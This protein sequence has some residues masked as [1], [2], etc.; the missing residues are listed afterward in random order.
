MHS[1]HGWCSL[2]MR[3]EHTAA[4]GMQ[5]GN[6]WRAFRCGGGSVAGPDSAGAPVQVFFKV[7]T[8]FRPALPEG[9]PPAYAELMAACW[10]EDADQ[11]PPFDDVLR[12]LQVPGSVR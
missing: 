4:A 11:R 5:K 7:L 6:G 1:A 9:A 8:G 12:E 10:S 3:G 2:H